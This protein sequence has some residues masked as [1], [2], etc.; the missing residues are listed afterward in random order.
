[1]KPILFATFFTL[2]FV[3]S[4]AQKGSFSGKIEG[5]DNA[6]INVLVL[7]LKLGETPISKNIQL[8]H[9]KFEC[10][11]DYNLNMWHLVRL[12]SKQFHTVF[13]DEK[14]PVEGLKNREIVFFIYPGEKLSIEAKIGKYGIDY[15]ISGN[16]IGNQS[17]LFSEQ[18]FPL[19]EELNRLTI[20]LA[21]LPENHAKQAELKTQIEKVISRMEKEKLELI[22][23]HPD[24]IYSAETLAEF[25][26]DTIA[27]YFKTFTTDVQN[28]FFGIHLSK[29]LNAAA[30][31]SVA[32]GF[33]LKDDKGKNVSLNEFAGKY[34]VLEF[35][36]TW[37][38][39]CIKE[40][41]R[42]KAC[43]SKYHDKVE[44]IGIDYKDSRQSWLKAISK[45]ELNW[46]NL[47]AEN[48]E[49]RDKYG[50]EGFPTKI[51]IDKEGKIVLKTTGESDEFYLKIDELFGNLEN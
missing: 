34:V 43:H 23:S 7:P 47:I 17:N 24:W 6:E 33:T 37:C 51:I 2:I 5:I 19:E 9:G 30:V 10:E 25:S 44:F 32:P 18:L 39:Y 26:N 14:E 4:N 16:E 36:G 31:G 49:V 45:Y 46:T 22:A 13:G 41:P 38:G 50:V 42:L 8:I 48:D 3:F 27:R 12:N 40:L 11:V 20:L 29:I 35:W 1:M 21:N 15:K 28:S